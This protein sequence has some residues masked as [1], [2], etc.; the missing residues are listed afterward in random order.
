MFN[1]DNKNF[2]KVKFEEINNRENPSQ[3]QI[4]DGVIEEMK[5]QLTEMTKLEYNET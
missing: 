2:L 3:K 4:Y 5:Y 1:P